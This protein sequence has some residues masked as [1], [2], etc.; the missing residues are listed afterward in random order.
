LRWFAER[1]FASAVLT[2][3]PPKLLNERIKGE[4]ERWY[5][6]EVMPE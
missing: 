6:K 1:G 5:D 2:D 3:L 4:F